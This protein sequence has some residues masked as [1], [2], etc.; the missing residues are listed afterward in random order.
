MYTPRNLPNRNCKLAYAFDPPTNTTQSSTIDDLHRK[1]YYNTHLNSKVAQ[2]P[3]HRLFQ[4]FEQLPDHIKKSSR[5]SFRWFCIQ[6]VLP[7]LTPEC[8]AL[9]MEL[10]NGTLFMKHKRAEFYRQLGRS[11][12]SGTTMMSITDL[13]NITGSNSDQI[14][15]LYMLLKNDPE[16]VNKC[17]EMRYSVKR[18]KTSSNRYQ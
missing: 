14:S 16:L 10:S 6:E 5:K 11:Q 7:I 13:Q 12:K 17:V 9:R 4:L 8:Q 18:S 1:I 3:R 2:S 15:T